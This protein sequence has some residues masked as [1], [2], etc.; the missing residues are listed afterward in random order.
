MAE[1]QSQTAM[2]VASSSP[3]TPKPS[4]TSGLTF[5]RFFTKAGVSPY[6]EVEWEKRNATITDSKGESSSSKKTSR[7]PRTGR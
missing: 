1:I 6:D 2:K 3:S 7:F 5:R 4:K